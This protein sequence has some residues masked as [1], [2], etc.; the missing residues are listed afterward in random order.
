M[1]EVKVCIYIAQYPVRWTAQSALHF[2]SPWQTCS[3]RHQLELSGKHSA[4]PQLLRRVYSLTL[5]TLSINRYSFIQQS[6][7][8][9]CEEN[10]NVP[11]FETAT[12]R[13]EPRLSRSRVW[14]STAELLCST[15][16]RTTD[17]ENAT[18][19]KKTSVKRLLLDTRHR[20]DIWNE[21]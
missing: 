14:D 21:K 20:G 4:M 17:Q 12:K 6:V 11:S 5:P 2:S 15:K 1:K 7:L 3:F 13:F 18:R 8:G 16:T 19:V 10:E 9:H